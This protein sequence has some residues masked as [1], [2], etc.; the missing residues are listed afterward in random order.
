MAH[1]LVSH[2][3]SLGFAGLSRRSR[4]LEEACVIGGDIAE[5]L[6]SV[7][8]AAEAALQQLERLSSSL[9]EPPPS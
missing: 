7:R 9:S 1:G 8:L 3:G 2:A 4:V 5:E 6:R